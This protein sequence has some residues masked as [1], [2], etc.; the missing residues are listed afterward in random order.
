[1]AEQDD[2]E[3]VEQQADGGEQEQ[4]A[5]GDEQGEQEQQQGAGKKLGGKAKR[6]LAP[7]NVKSS[8]RQCIVG[9]ERQEG[10]LAGLEDSNSTYVER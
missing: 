5:D 2:N 9:Q 3:V 8:E 6:T 10:Q 1:M 7:D 4:Q